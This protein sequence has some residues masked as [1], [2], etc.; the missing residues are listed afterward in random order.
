VVRSPKSRGKG[1]RRFPGRPGGARK[2]KGIGAWQHRCQRL[3]SS[4]T[5][6]SQPVASLWYGGAWGHDLEHR[7]YVFDQ[8]MG[9]LGVRYFATIR[10]CYRRQAMLVTVAQ[11]QAA[12]VA[13]A[14]ARLERQ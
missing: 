10:V 12:R 2:A 3:V 6:L 8:Q 5:E 9:K 7:A 14:I 1:S 13:E 4:P 11:S